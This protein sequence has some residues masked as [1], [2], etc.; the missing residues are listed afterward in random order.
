RRPHPL[1]P[2]GR[3]LEGIEKERSKTSFL[4]GRADHILDTSDFTPHQLMEAVQ[5]LFM[6]SEEKPKLLL[7][8][9]SFGFKFG[10]PVDSDLLFDVRFMPN[11]YWVKELRDYTGLQASVIDYVMKWPVSRIFLNKLVEMMAFLLP[12]YTLEGKHQLV[13]AIGCTGGRHRSVTVAEK[14]ADELRLLGYSVDVTHRDIKKRNKDAEK[15]EDKII[16]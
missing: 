10:L 9:V 1:L 6:Q 2:N 14:L 13:I 12:N 4:K 3:L 16:P 5:Q 15:A 11:P 8:I 7:H